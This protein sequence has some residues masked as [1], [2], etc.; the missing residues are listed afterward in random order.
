LA[1]FERVD[2]EQALE[3]LDETLE[4]S[5]RNSDALVS[6]VEILQLMGQSD[7]SQELAREYLEA[8]KGLDLWEWS[9]LILEYLAGYKTEEELLELAHP[10]H[11]QV[12]YARYI[13]GS[14]HRARGNREKAKEHFQ[15]VL[16]TG[17]IGWGAYERSKVYLKRLEENPN[18]LGE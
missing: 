15:A 1:L 3:V 10:F 18:W 12:C 9:F 2:R 6:A 16:D 8:R 11:S 4:R 5:K 17:R 13:V 7:R 14:S